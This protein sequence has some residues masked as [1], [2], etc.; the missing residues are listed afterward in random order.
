MHLSGG[1]DSSLVVALASHHMEHPIQ[2]LTDCWVPNTVQDERHYARTVSKRYN[3]QHHEVVLSQDAPD[4]ADTLRRMLWFLD[5]PVAG[6]GVIPQYWVSHLCS[7]YVKVVLGGQ[8][9][10]ELFGGYR[11]LLPALVQS[12]LLD[13]I[14]SPG[15]ASVQALSQTLMTFVGW[16]KPQKVRRAIRRQLH[17]SRIDWL[18]PDYAATLRSSE[19]TG[20][21]V[22]G[23]NPFDR[24]TRNLITG[25]LVSLLQIEDRTSMTVSIESRV[26]LLDY[27]VVEL[28]VSMPCS[29][30]TRERETKLVVDA[31]QRNG[32][33]RSFWRA[34]TR[35]ASR[36]HLNSGT[37]S[38]C[39]RW[40]FR[41]WIKRSFKHG[42]S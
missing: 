35:S 9:G 29:L 6:P 16:L 23:F 15:I 24:A 20:P 26:P 1:F 39:G 31:W 5:E 28:A 37:V 18:T 36:R 10:D 14:R 22:K 3:T 32:C 4:Y 11:S 42:R 25:Y 2:T 40:R 30:K 17:D 33:H 21:K 41:P 38:L 7:R 19:S 12:R 27:R 8:G 34:R 13:T